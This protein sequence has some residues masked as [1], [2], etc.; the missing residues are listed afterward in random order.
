MFLLLLFIFPFLE[1]YLFYQ[2]I[3]NFGF[4]DTVLWI[5]SAFALGM[6]LTVIMGRSI[7]L[8]IQMD[9]AQGRMPVRKALHKGLIVFAGFLFMV[10]GIGTDIVAALLVLPISRHLIVFYLEIKLKH[11]IAKGTAKFFTAG[12]QGF[13]GTFRGG[14]FSG[15]FRR[16]SSFPEEGRF[17]RDAEVIDVTPIQIDSKKKDN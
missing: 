6:A 9:L 4:I 12:A 10:P 15:G 17:E 13:S 1:I 16:E 14:G 3:V 7:L 11:A 5:I 8:S 2:A